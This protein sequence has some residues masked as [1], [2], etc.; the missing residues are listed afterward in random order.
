[1][2]KVR[3]EFVRRLAEYDARKR[4]A[5]TSMQITSKQQAVRYVRKNLTVYCYGDYRF[6][7]KQLELVIAK[8]WDAAVKT[9]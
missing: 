5:D 6:D 9:P 2:S 8:I 3:Q 1:M 4:F 7:D